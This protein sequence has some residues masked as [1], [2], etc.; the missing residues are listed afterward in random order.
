MERTIKKW[1]KE[2]KFIINDKQFWIVPYNS[3]NWAILTEMEELPEN[4]VKNLKSTEKNPKKCKHAR[5]VVG[6]YRNMEDARDEL[7]EF[8]VKECKT[9]KELCKWITAIKES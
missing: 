3:L 5:K 2:F 1:D 6:F 8:G 9:Y 4:I 7:K